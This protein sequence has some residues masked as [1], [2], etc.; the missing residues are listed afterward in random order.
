MVDGESCL[1]LRKVERAYRVTRLRPDPQVA[2][3]Q[4]VDLTSLEGR[5]SKDYETKQKIR[6]AFTTLLDKGLA[7]T[8]ALVVKNRPGRYA[9]IRK[10][11][12]EL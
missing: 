2:K 10:V 5:M 9:A 6:E 3:A 12:G 11:G 8:R 1:A 4:G 7:G